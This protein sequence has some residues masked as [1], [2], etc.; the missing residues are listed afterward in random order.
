MTQRRSGGGCI[1]GPILPSVLL[2]TIGACDKKAA[3]DR[4][5]PSAAEETTSSAKVSPAVV[6]T[7]E[8]SDPSSAPPTGAA[9]SLVNA[10][11][12]HVINLIGQPGALWSPWD[13]AILKDLPLPT[14]IPTTIPTTIPTIPAAWPAPL[15]VPTATQLPGK[16]VPVV[17]LYGA[18]WCPHCKTAK[19]HIEAR[20]IK[21]TYRDVDNADANSELAV[22]L[23]NAGQTKSGI[24]TI[25]VDGDLMVGWSEQQFDQTYDAKAK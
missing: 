18:D 17:I 4:P 11:P 10:K 13:L 2:A 9:P 8:A 20:S 19:A 5:P 16:H 24:P 7:V 25:D 21:Y 14:G 6:H 1:G 23:K 12:V 22:K 15:P 3:D